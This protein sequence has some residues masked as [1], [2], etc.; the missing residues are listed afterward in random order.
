M[1]TYIKMKRKEHKFKLA[2]YSAL[3]NAFNENENFIN[4]VKNLYISLKDVPV[5]QLQEIFI[6]KLAEIIHEDNKNGK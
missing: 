5:E 2:L 6:S 4:T 3:I 1:I